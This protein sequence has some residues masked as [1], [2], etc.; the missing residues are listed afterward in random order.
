MTNMSFDELCEM[1]NYIPKNRPLTTREYA[2][3]RSVSERTIHDERLRGS[4]PRYFQP[5]RTKI[6]LYSE[7]DV[8]AWIAAGMKHSTSENAA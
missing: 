8:L 4:G 7:K 1:F 2:E 3:L 5:E 6:V